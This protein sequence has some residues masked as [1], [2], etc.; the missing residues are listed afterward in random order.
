MSIS[1]FTIENL[2]M[3]E[4]LATYFDKSVPLQMIERQM[5]ILLELIEELNIYRKRIKVGIE[6]ALVQNTIQ[7]YIKRYLHLEKVIV[8]RNLKSE[9]FR[10]S[11]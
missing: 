3:T 7:S 9:S 1:N 4:D 11:M 8:E 5:D 2:G 10:E 6:R